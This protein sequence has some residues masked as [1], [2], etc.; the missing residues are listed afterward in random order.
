MKHYPRIVRLST[1]GL[2]QHQAFDYEFHAFRTDFIGESGC[3]KSMIADLLQL[4]LVGSEHF[5][6]A[7]DAMGGP[8]L[9]EGMVLRSRDRRGTE[10]GYAC[11]TIEVANEKFVVIGAYIETSAR[12]TT[13]FVI[14]AGYEEEEIA[15]MATIFS[16]RDLL[17]ANKILPL[18]D[19]KTY[20]EARNM[21]CQSWYH[22]K[23]YYKF[24]YENKILS[25]DLSVGDKIIKD[26]AAIIQSFSRGK[27][28]DTQKG[29]LLK[30]VLV[31]N[32]TAKALQARYQEAVLELRTA[33][34]E[35]GQNRKEIDLI[36]RKQKSLNK[37]LEQN[38]EMETIHAEWLHVCSANAV[39]GGT[40]D[41]R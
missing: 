14:Q 16:Y 3:G 19:L 2:R 27:S 9:P 26:F 41:T 21:I 6:S 23:G 33:F 8:R 10:I 13:A 5:Y 30:Q 24:L 25:L 34:D 18:E 17:K 4:I 11:L 40:Q 7:T 31:G 15:P 29:E 36:I 28:I 38:K 39:P 12:N 35:Y 37:I 22:K 20:L 1:V 32:E